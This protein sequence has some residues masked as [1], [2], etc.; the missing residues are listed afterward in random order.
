[1]IN[2]LANNIT[3]ILLLL[4]L[5]A[6]ALTGSVIYDVVNT[7]IIEINLIEPRPFTFCEYLSWV[8]L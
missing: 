7:D 5:I 1:M 2:F 6:S 8:R 3:S 4:I